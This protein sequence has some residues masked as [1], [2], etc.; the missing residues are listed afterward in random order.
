M[1]SRITR[2]AVAIASLLAVAC[3]ESPA[4]PTQTTT[5]SSGPDATFVADALNYWAGVLGV[6]VSTTDTNTQPRILFREGTDGLGSGAAGRAL[7]DGADAANWATSGLVVVRP[8]V[9][10]RYL[11]RHEMGHALGFLDHSDGGLMA[12]SGGPEVLSDR[13]RRMMVALYSL[14]AGTRVEADGRWVGPQGEAGQIEPEAAGD[15]LRF[16][17][18]AVAG[19]GVRRP[20][21]TCRLASP[22]RVFVQR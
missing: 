12:A 5:G 11:Y 1:G 8:G 9:A 15:I 22:A 7:I 17:V 16:N 18:N 20:G 14:P 3:S 6:T 19:S 2:V 4:M 10:S 13:E 21:L